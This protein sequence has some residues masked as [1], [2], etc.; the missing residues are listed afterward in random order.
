METE[1]I[2]KNARTSG[3]LKPG[4]RVASKAE[5]VGESLETWNDSAENFS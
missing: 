5:A 4:D 1:L 2:N 3:M